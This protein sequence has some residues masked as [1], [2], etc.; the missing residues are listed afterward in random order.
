[1]NIIKTWC[2]NKIKSSFVLFSHGTIVK[3]SSEIDQIL[4]QPKQC[5]E[6]EQYYNNVKNLREF[7][8]YNIN[9]LSDN[10][11]SVYYKQAISKLKYVAPGLET[12]DTFITYLK[13]DNM[14]KCQ[15]RFTNIINVSTHDKLKNVYNKVD[16]QAPK[17]LDIEKIALH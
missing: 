3:V 1:M 11:L 8:E 7:V 14:W 13:D 5:F 16:P 4:I 9:E 17:I 15:W 10:L 12:S 2:I 6:S